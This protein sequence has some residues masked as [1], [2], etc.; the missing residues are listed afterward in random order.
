MGYHKNDVENLCLTVP[1]KIVRGPFD[2][3]E[4]FWHSLFVTREYF[5]SKTERGITKIFVSEKKYESGS[6][7]CFEKI[8]FSENFIHKTGII[9]FVRKLSHSGE[10]FRKGLF[11][12][13]ES[14]W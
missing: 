10:K 6:F 13:S 5:G 1:K 12:V 4:K 8:A 7:C 3:S 14:F 11:G 9:T 2:F